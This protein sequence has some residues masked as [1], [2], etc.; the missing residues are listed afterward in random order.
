MLDIDAPWFRQRCLGR[1]VE[2][3]DEKRLARWTF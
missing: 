3:F 1:D 2:Y